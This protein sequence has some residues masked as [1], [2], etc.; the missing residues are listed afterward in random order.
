M[1]QI[2]KLVLIDPSSPA[3][4]K[5]GLFD[6]SNSVLNR[7][8]TLSP[9]FRLKSAL[10]CDG[11]SV[12]TAD[13]LWQHEVPECDYYNLGMLDSFRRLAHQE[14]VRLKAFLI[15]EP[16]V[17]APSLYRALPELTTA[18][19]RVYVHNTIGD[20]YSLERVNQSKLRRLFWP[21]PREDVIAALWQRQKR[22]RRFV[23][24]NGNHK[25]AS[26]RE[27]ELYSR[28]IE[29]LVELSQFGVVDL[30]GRG[31]EK[32][33]LRRSMWMPYWKN[34][35]T[36]MSIYKGACASKYEV[37]SSYTFALCFENMAM[38]GYVTEK[39]F[40]CFYAGTIPVYL[41]APDIADI[42]P[43]EAYIDYRQFGTTKEMLD[44]ILCLS[45]THIQTMREAGRT[46]LRSSQ[47]QRFYNS[48]I[49]IF[50]AA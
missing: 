31:W 12:H 7:D 34:H 32:W 37:L 27:R 13:Y 8:D 28:R 29:T 9:F 19:E 35:K 24:I 45:E 42:V 25:P 15:M 49:E 43:E 3:Y 14:G 41:G 40:D 11:A 33:W 26:D 46:F 21:Q 5:D 16:P 4:Y 36:L 10:E 20:G 18:F 22:Q 50:N 2:N 30:Y 39:I 44:W 47:G 6:V 23:M 38:K 1:S 48:L 17:V